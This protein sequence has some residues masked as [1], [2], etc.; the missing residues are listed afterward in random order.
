MLRVSRREYLREEVTIK[1]QGHLVMVNTMEE[2]INTQGKVS[3]RTKGEILE[4][5]AELMEVDITNL[6]REA[7]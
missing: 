4:E 1:N 5:R 7:L 6:I 3:K 2:V